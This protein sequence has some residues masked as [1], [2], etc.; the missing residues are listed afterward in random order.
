VWAP[1]VWNEHKPGGATAV[2]SHDVAQHG[3]DS[4]GAYQ[5]GVFRRPILRL[6][7]DWPE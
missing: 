1:V 4:G 2:T 5:V 6:P 3:R 7:G